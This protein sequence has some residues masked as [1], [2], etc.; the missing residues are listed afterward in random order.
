MAAVVVLENSNFHMGSSSSWSQRRRHLPGGRL[1]EIRECSSFGEQSDTGKI[2]GFG[3]DPNRGSLLLISL[4]LTCAQ[5]MRDDI[6]IHMP[7]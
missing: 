7:T 1:D 5:N 2:N 6:H 3:R 4:A